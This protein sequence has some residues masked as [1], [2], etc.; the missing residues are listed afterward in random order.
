MSQT[1]S[2]VFDSPECSTVEQ[3]A[4][5]IAVL[6]YAVTPE[7]QIRQKQRRLGIVFRNGFPQPFRSFGAV[8]ALAICAV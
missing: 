2:R 7:I 3:Q 1:L 8:A 6:R 5:L 4:G